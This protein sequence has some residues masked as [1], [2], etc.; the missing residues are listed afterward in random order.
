[1]VFLTTYNYGSW[2]SLWRRSVTKDLLQAT[3]RPVC[4]AGADELDGDY[5]F[6]NRRI[7]CVVGL[8]GK[9]TG[10]IEQAQEIARRASAELVLLH[11]IPDPNE[12]LLSLAVDSE[13]RPL[14]RQRAANDLAHLVDT[15]RMPAVTSVMVGDPRKCIPLAS[16][17][18]SV[19]LVMMS[20]AGTRSHGVYSNDVKRVLPL[21]RCPLLTIPVDGRVPAQPMKYERRDIAGRTGVRRASAAAFFQ[22]LASDR[23]LPQEPISAVTRPS[24]ASPPDTAV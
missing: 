17:E 6:R 20:R 10:L 3:S 9:E 8:D 21:L 5:R 24:T 13:T 14:S 23:Y 19:D 18:H 22:A 11:V 15:L 16:R 12:A 4:I 1:M 7:L 2:S